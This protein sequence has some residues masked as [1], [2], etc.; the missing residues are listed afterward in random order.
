MSTRL[1]L[2]DFVSRWRDTKLSEKAGAQPHFIALCA[3]LGEPSPA[4]S[5]QTGQ[6]YTFEK[7]VTKTGG[8]KGFADVW[9]RGY[10]AWE[11]KAPG[12]DLT[13]AYA[14]LL[15]YREPLEN[16]PLLVVCDLL[17]FQ[18][19][20]NF[21][22]TIKQTYTFTL[23]DLLRAEPTPTSALPPLD[24][25]RAVFTAPEQL[26]PQQTTAKVT[27]AAAQKFAALAAS[28]RRRGVD[29]HEAAHFLMRLLF[30]LF[31]ED[32]GLLPPRIFTDMVE[33]N[34]MRPL[35]F[36]LRLRALFAA[37]AAG[38]D[39]GNAE[40]RR[41]NGGLFN[42][43]TGIDLIND[44]LLVLLDA[45][46]L[47][48]SSVEP[49]IFG[50]LF[51]RSLD[52]TNRTRLGAHYTSRDDILLLVKPVLMSPLYR[53]WAAVQ[54]EAVA[55]ETRRD[56]ATGALR[57]AR[58]QELMRL[59]MGFAAEIARTRVLDP[60]CG[61]GNFLY[62]ALK[63]L[64]DLEKAVINFAAQHTGQSFFPQGHPEQLYGIEINP[65]AQELAS[66]VVWIGYIQW[67]RDNGFGF[68][69]DPVLRP[70]HNIRQM[71][72]ILAYDE[73]GRPVEP[74]WPAVDV[75][76]GNPPFLGGNKIRKE[77][78]D[79]YVD[80]LFKLYDPVMPQFADLVC[81][82]F[83]RTRALIANGSVQRAGLLA[84]NSI[85]GGVN[86]QVLERIKE[87]GDIFWAE[88][89]RKWILKGAS[90]HVSMVGFDQG[91]ETTRVLDSQP[92][93][94]INADLTPAIDLTA[95][96]P[97]AE[98]MAICFMGPSPKAPFDIPESAALLMLN[99]PVNVN[100]R[101][102][103]DVVRPVASGIDLVRHARHEWTIDFGSMSLEEA[104]QY[105]HPFEY[106]RTYVYPIRVQAEKA[107]YGIKWWQYG[108][109]RVEMR[110]ALA[111]KSRF[112]ATPAVSKHRIFVWVDS[113]VLCNQGTLVFARED[114]YFL[115][116]LQA[117]PHLLWALRLGTALEDR[118]RYTPTST[119]EPFPFPWPPGQEPA[120]D[121]RVEAVATAAR[122][123]V[124]KREAWLNPA[125]ATPEQLAERTLTKLYN[126]QPGWL[127]QAH[128]RLDAAVLGAYGW[129]VHL[130]DEEILSRLLDL[131]RA[132]ASG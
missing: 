65:Y 94:E 45:C 120:G 106:V 25:L 37:M 95:A 91:T 23:D 77:L 59:L 113:R 96:E 10:F 93:G 21:T 57:A 16:P 87:T 125:G 88:S 29:A 60:A 85:R 9:K 117:K 63:A 7:G 76:L 98:N 69:A 3:A 66:V 79:K 44:D 38:G 108:R 62:V 8:G 80:S 53:R 116:V 30:C 89:D 48:W 55:L 61:S 52:P 47:D 68:P 46:R 17:T 127:Q 12:E 18:V 50:T 33:T 122:D 73:A 75:I 74:P 100:G 86:R 121:P 99:A 36:T 5:D 41:F 90:V 70:L 43:D 124:A 22:N 42:D 15:Q 130:T 40:I 123:L 6:T 34:L 109:P 24:V 51:E 54:E 119:F 26:R 1:T 131:N 114:D 19:H 101:P 97:L 81:Y 27:E 58:A 111:G 49:A 35:R 39:Y 72:A 11:Y 92:V 104:S 4:Q 103:S 126:D 82:W 32:I 129:P 110:E 20:T 102:N 13:A 84:T 118:P 31:A 107:K 78:G 14:Q 71:D 128:A 67:L 56:A 83:E 2:P 64:L 105:E 132:R 112:I 115:G 28:L